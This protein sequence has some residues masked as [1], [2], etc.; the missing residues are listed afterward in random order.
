MGT[1][2]SFKYLMPPPHPLCS[3]WT[4]VRELVPSTS[5]DFLCEEEQDT[6]TVLLILW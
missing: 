6:S 3:E 1:H 2:E 5:V 4:S